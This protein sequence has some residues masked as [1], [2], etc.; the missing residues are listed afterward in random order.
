[1][2]FRKV[3]TAAA[4]LT[5]C[6]LILTA[7]GKDSAEETT[8]A[9]DSET[10]TTTE[11]S[12]ETT[13]ETTTE[14]APND[15]SED[16]SA[17]VPEDIPNEDNAEEQ[18][19][20]IPAEGQNP[21]Q[22]IAD[23]ALAVGEWPSLWEVTD[24]QLI[25]DFFLLDAANENYQNLLILQCPMSAN[26]TEIIIIKAND[27]SAAKADLEARQKKAQE[28]DAFYPDD[29]ERAAASVVGT[30]GD[31]AYFLVGDN[32]PEAETEIVNYI[33]NM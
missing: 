16:L 3:I 24:P 22:P 32:T 6:A 27:V 2:K 19:E 25:S 23:A 12:S 9:P 33:K 10:E 5:A 28:Q 29:V 13:E 7:C 26:M 30:E 31:Y 4:V 17:D 20:E 15:V 11:S 8:S 1:M 18:P 21:L 14:S